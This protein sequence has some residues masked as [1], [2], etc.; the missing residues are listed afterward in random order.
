VEPDLAALNKLKSRNAFSFFELLALLKPNLSWTWQVEKFKRVLEIEHRTKTE[1]VTDKL[2]SYGVVHRKLIPETIH[3]AS[4][5]ANNRTELL[6]E[7]A[8]VR[9]HSM[10]KFKPVHQAQRFLGAHVAVYNLLNLGRYLVWAE[11]D[12]HFRLRA[13]AS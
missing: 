13:F 7:P 2:R 3:D 9:E 1:I 5:Y 10:R 11:H 4:Q 12:R 6:L 8:R